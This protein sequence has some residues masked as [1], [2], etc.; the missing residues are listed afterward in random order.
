MH[1]YTHVTIVS[2]F[3]DQSSL[4]FGELDRAIATLFRIA[5]G[6]TWVPDMPVYDEKSGLVDWAVGVYVFSFVILVNWTLIQVFVCVTVNLRV[7]EIERAWRC[8]WSV[9]VLQWCG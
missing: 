7:S 5:A 4:A 3:G 9:G 2:L 8:V 6:E 1:T